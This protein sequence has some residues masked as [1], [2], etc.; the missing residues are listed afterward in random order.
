MSETSINTLFHHTDPA[1]VQQAADI[2]GARDEDN[3]ELGYVVVDRTDLNTVVLAELL[4]GSSVDM[5]MLLSKLRKLKPECLGLEIY[6]DDGR[7]IE[8]IYYKNGSKVIKNTVINT[9][10]K[11]CLEFGLYYSLKKADN[12]TVQ[13]ILQNETINADIAIGGT[14][15]VFLV[16][17]F[18][19][20]K[21]FKLLLERGADIDT[22]IGSDNKTQNRKGECVYLDKGTTLL[23]AAVHYGSPNIAAWLIKHGSN[24]NAVDRN[25]DNAL[26]LMTRDTSMHDLLIPAIEAG[27]DVNHENA[28]GITPLFAMIYADGKSQKYIIDHC[29]QLI[30][31]GAD[32]KH[33]SRNGMNAR[34][35]AHMAETYSPQRKVVNFVESF[36]ITDCHAPDDFY[37]DSKSDWHTLQ[38]AFHYNDKETFTSLFT[39]DKLSPKGMLALLDTRPHQRNSDELLRIMFDKGAPGFILGSHDNIDNITSVPASRSYLKEVY[40]KSQPA[41][42]EYLGRCKELARQF[43]EYLASYTDDSELP[44]YIPHEGEQRERHQRSSLRRFA[45]DAKSADLDTMGSFLTQKLNA[46]YAIRLRHSRKQLYILADPK[47][48]EILKYIAAEPEHA[49][50]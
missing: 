44:E 33:V 13:Q 22:V 34:W 15:L 19:D 29:K 12:E 23:M 1:I 45:D 48:M 2:I 36:G 31:Q 16:I 10:R 41:K 40:D 38:R 7:R 24:I 17:E 14:P 27:T 42:D 28:Q 8:P 46:C 18:D 26:L 11:E 6:P 25:G 9:L 21:A 20:V 43:T 37:D 3:R 49:S 35:A 30:D 39:P 32:I 47:T 4:G 50:W 5:D